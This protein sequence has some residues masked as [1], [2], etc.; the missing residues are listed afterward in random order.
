MRDHLLDFITQKADF[1]RAEHA[2]NPYVFL[3]LLVI[4]APFFYFSAYRLFRALAARKPDPIIRWS[5]VFL[6]ATAVPYLYVLV[7]GRNLPWWV[8]LVIVLLLGQGVFSLVRK[9]RRPAPD[10]QGD[11][12]DKSIE[13]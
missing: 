8:Y 1:I 5:S 4:C 10:I 6:A 11:P 13:K 12:G 9:L 7:F 2:V 3:L